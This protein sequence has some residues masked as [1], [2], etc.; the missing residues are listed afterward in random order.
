MNSKPALAATELQDRLA[1]SERVKGES[2][3]PACYRKRSVP[4]FALTTSNLRLASG[5]S[6]RL[7][8]SVVRNV[9]RPEHRQ[10]PRHPLRERAIFD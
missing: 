10:L 9:R 5:F 7:F 1:G 8:S 4:P 2:L 3:V 6:S